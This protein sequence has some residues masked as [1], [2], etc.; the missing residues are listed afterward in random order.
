M[1][2]KRPLTT[3]PSRRNAR[4]DLRSSSICYP[5]FADH[6]GS[7]KRLTSLQCCRETKTPRLVERVLGDRIPKEEELF[8]ECRLVRGQSSNSSKMLGP[9]RL[10]TMLLLKGMQPSSMVSQN[11]DWL[12]RGIRCC[13]PI[14]VCQIAQSSENTARA[15]SLHRTEGQILDISDLDYPKVRAADDSGVCG[16]CRAPRCY[17]PVKGSRLASLVPAAARC[18]GPSFVISTRIAL[19]ICTSQGL[20]TRLAVVVLHAAAV[21]AFSS[22]FPTVFSIAV[23][24]VDFRIM[25]LQPSSKSVCLLFPC[26]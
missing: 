4:P 26:V 19:V 15:S 1:I 2:S 22:N 21:N 13:L 11:A 12:A 14:T 7:T 5:A 9:H 23:A 18:L 24:A 3:K 6:H 8:V 20:H 17:W 10:L 25:C 16:A